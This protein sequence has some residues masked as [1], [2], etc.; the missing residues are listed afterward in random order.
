MTTFN[1][2]STQQLEQRRQR[3]EIPHFWNVLTDDYFTGQLIPGSRRV[4]LDRV[5]DEA[6]RLDLDEDVE[7]VVYCSGPGCPQSAA[8]AEK[9]AGFGF[10]N[11]H[12]YEGGLAAWNEAGFETEE[13]SVG[14]VAD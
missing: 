9:L 6:R 11:V 8:A 4:P 13:A 10:R 1:T 2:I 12:L 7:I 5:V 3:V 14:T